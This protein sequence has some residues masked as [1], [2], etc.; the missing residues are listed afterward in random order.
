VSLITSGAGVTG[1]VSNLGQTFNLANNFNGEGFLDLLNVPAGT[2]Q[3][4]CNMD[5]SQYYESDIASFTAGSGGGSG[6]ITFIQSQ[7]G[8]VGTSGNNTATF[9]GQP[10]AGDTVVV[11]V[12]CFGPSDCQV[13]SITDNFNNS[14]AQIGPS[15][16]Y[17]GP[18]ANITRVLLYCASGIA[19]GTNFTVTAA[20]SNPGSGADSNLYIA[21]YSGA[22]C[23][24]D[25][26]TSG[27][28][29][30]GSPTT[31]LQTSSITTTNANDLLV[32][33]AGA[34]TGGVAT[35]G[36]GYHL[37]QNGNSGVAE[38]GGFEDKTVTA[39][40]SYSASMTLASNTTY[41]AMVMVALKGASGS[42]S[43][44]SITSFT[45]TSGPV[46]T[47]VTITGTNFTGATAVKFN[48]TPAASFT[49]NN[50]TQIT[51]TV[52][53]A[54]TSGPISVTT[55][56]GTG[57]STASF[58]VTGSSPIITRLSP[59][60]GPVG[61]SVTITGA[62]FGSTPGTVTFT[63]GQTAATTDWKPTAIIAA[64][65]SGA[66]TG[67]VVVTVGSATSNTKNFTVTSATGEPNIT[68]VT[69][70]SGSA[71]TSST[72]GT[73]VTIAGNGFGLSQGSGVVWLG[74]KPGVVV[75]WGQNQIVATVA[76]GAVT[77]SAR[78]LQNGQF[79]N[80]VPFTVN[81]SF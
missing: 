79:S 7:T 47:S 35:P 41:W 63:S 1:C 69:P 58:T 26:S 25:Q 40:G 77:G 48:G 76:Q 60:S 67:P 50:S 21:E 66:I 6:G 51:A 34:T 70:T 49:I 71:G 22:T 19:T 37:R 45:P 81:C 11:G 78:V 28:E 38:F 32:A 14:Y 52:P 61:V 74:S 43:A 8:A 10:A 68:S 27:S 30:A 75:T 23:N 64:V 55:P 29:T 57:T 54:A 72:A 65:P 12:V 9:S 59:P 16:S 62:N 33:V 3:A 24:V 31:L 4:K 18:T 13:T 80:S 17:G 53:P 46:N 73:Q 2:Y 5:S 42:G 36:F 39:T 20:L 44:P 56:S 15:A